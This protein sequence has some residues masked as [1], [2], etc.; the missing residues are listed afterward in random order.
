MKR[1]GMLDGPMTITA[2]NTYGSIFVDQ[3]NSL[4]VEAM[5]Q[6]FLDSQGEHVRCRASKRV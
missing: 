2:K 6:L 1:M 4:H 5:R 3:L